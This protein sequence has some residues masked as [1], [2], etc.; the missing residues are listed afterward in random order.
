VQAAAISVQGTRMVVVLVRREVIDDPGEAALVQGAMQTRFGGAP[1]VL[2]GQDEDG[3]PHFQG[4][5]AL[6]A[7]LQGL[8]IER[9]PWT[10]HPAP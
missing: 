5:P 9:M 1:V 10:S 7:L 3:T 8:P 2:M 4:E 6:L